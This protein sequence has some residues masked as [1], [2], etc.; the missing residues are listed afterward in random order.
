MTLLLQFIPTVRQDLSRY[1]V[2]SRLRANTTHEEGGTIVI[3]SPP[4]IETVGKDGVG[5]VGD[6]VP[7]EP[8]RGRQGQE[9]GILEEKILK[10][11]PHGNVK[12]SSLEVDTRDRSAPRVNYELWV[13]GK[14]AW[15]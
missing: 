5:A 9:K 11:M 10:Y 15:Q 13:D 3:D 2:P 8:V 14:M 7:G 6:G 1:Y 4:A 12:W